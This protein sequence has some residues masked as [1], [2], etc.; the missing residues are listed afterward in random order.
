MK[1]IR[2]ALLGA[3]FVGTLAATAL[4]APDSLTIKMNALNGSGEN[5]T[6]T[7]T[8]TAEGVTVA[9]ALDGAPTDVPQPTHIHIG[10]CGHINKAPEYALKNTVD[11]KGES[12]VGGI[13]LANLLSGHYAV[14]VHKSG[15]DLGTYVSCGDIK[16][17]SK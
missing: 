3:A 15:T 11:G 7:L 6:A 4:A 9:V 16:E 8:Q 13:K 17:P 5:G 10:T 1:I 2:T 14:N 12:T